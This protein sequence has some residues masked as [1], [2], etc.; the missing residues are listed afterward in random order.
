MKYR[1]TKGW[2]LEK[3]KYLSSGATSVAPSNN[4]FLSHGFPDTAPC[5]TLAYCRPWL[6]RVQ[7]KNEH[8]KAIPIPLTIY[9]LQLNNNPSL[10]TDIN[11]CIKKII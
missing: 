11:E 5:P 7:Q 4:L 1:K 8:S 3:N 2:R 10:T 6:K 9:F